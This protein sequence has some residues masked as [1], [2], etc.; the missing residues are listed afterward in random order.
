M[1]HFTLNNFVSC[2][3]VTLDP[4]HPSVYYLTA[5]E[6]QNIHYFPNIDFRIIFPI[7]R[8]S[9][10]LVVGTPVSLAIFCFACVMPKALFHEKDKPGIGML[11]FLLAI[12]SVLYK[13]NDNQSAS[14][15]SVKEYLAALGERHIL[16]YAY[17]LPVGDIIHSL[18]PAVDENPLT[19]EEVEVTHGLLVLCARLLIAWHEVV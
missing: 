5:K 18:Q 11:D 12:I 17:R 13:L 8:S 10:A 2:F 4:W 1:L 9:P 6:I 19:V 16:P 15:P 14:L 7:L 3:I